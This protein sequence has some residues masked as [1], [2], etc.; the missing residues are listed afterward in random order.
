ME[1]LLV[2]T[3]LA[4]A[5]V[6]GVFL[7]FSDFIMS[8]LARIEP[9]SGRSAMQSINTRVYGSGFLVLLLGLGPVALALGAYGFA[10]AQP[11]LVAG[12]VSYVAGVIGVTMVG[13]VP[14]NKRLDVGAA[15]APYWPAYQRDWTRLNHIRSAASTIS[16]ACYLM[17]LV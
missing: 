15:A 7:A 10:T 1:F 11:W 4:T 12:G 3:A 16:A 5:L 13:N 17:A 6:A 2:A 9:D 8:S 14:M